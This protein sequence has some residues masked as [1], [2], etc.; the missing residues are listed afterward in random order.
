[1]PVFKIETNKKSTKKFRNM[2]KFFQA[3]SLSV[4]SCIRGLLEFY[5]LCTDSFDTHC[6]LVNKYLRDNF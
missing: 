1:M 4:K 6:T 5:P 3:L 2:V